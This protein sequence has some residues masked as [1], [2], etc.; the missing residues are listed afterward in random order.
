MSSLL[1]LLEIAGLSTF[2]CTLH[3]QQERIGPAALYATFG[4]MSCLLFLIE[5]HVRVQLWGATPSQL[6]SL[7]MVPVMLVTVVL[8]YV[9]DGTRAAR[10]FMVAIV[11]V[12]LV[13]LVTYALVKHHIFHPPAGDPIRAT[14]TVLLQTSTDVF[15]SL[16]A[17]LIDSVTL[18]LVFQ[19]LRNR[20]PIQWLF[21]PLYVGLVVA[22]GVDGW[23]YSGLHGVAP[24]WDGFRLPEKLQAGLAAGLPMAIY[25][26]HRLALNPDLSQRGALD[27][28]DLR[29]R[30][31]QLEERNTRLR[32]LFSRY[33]SPE[34]VDT[35]SHSSSPLDL[36]GEAR[37]VTVMFS[38]LRGFSSLGEVLS[39]AELVELINQYLAVACPPIL[40][41]GGMINEVEGDGILAIFGAPMAL[42]DH[43]RAAVDAG[44]E[45]RRRVAELDERI[46]ASA[47]NS[48]ARA[49]LDRLTVRVGVHTGE[50]V[51]GHIGTERR[52]KYAA[53]GDAVNMAAR[54][55]SLNKELGTTLLLTEE[56]K[57]SGRM[58]DLVLTDQ[59]VVQ[60]RGR[61]GEVQVYSLP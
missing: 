47:D 22:M 56:T 34:V 37:T 6:S 36:R 45:I 18:I 61:R 35:L 50:V 3:S 27:I 51:L 53:I 21:V 55:E 4:L 28:I 24:S 10:R 25:I 60:L 12:Y 52:S 54:V 32:D 26:R 1:P 46:R 42:E 30:L 16:I 2:V 43:A 38:D 9:L 5:I 39:P 11:A 49:G 8:I 44:I 7:L 41:A 19:F 14:S 40:D 31:S 29:D 48:L 33:V 13:Q 58:D 20:M 15:A 57:R 23:A 59:G 17:V